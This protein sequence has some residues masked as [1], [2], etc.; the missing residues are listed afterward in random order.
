MRNENYSELKWVLTYFLKQGWNMPQFYTGKHTVYVGYT[1][2]EPEKSGDFQN[3]KKFNTELC[4]IIELLSF[5]SRIA[6]KNDGSKW[7]AEQ[8]SQQK[9]DDFMNDPGTYKTYS[10]YMNSIQN[11]AHVYSEW[12]PIGDDEYYCKCKKCPSYKTRKPA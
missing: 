12:M 4:A 10:D 7:V 11:C 1:E 8:W 2:P 5:K 9:Y 3:A 6:N